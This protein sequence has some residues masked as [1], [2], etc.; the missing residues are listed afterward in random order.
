VIPASRSR[1]WRLWAPV[2][3]AIVVVAAVAACG[4]PAP[5]PS[6]PE[7]T[8]TVTPGP[9]AT[10]MPTPT[11]APVPTATPLASMVAVPT[12]RLAAPSAP[13]AH[14]DAAKTKALQTALIG[15][16][17]SNKLPG[18]SAAVLFPD[19]SIWTGVSGSAVV[20]KTSVTTDTLFSVGSIT[21]TFVAAL[22]GR[23]AMAGTIGLDDPLSKY[24]PDF[25]NAANI[26]LR[27]LLNHT[28][29]IDD[30]FDYQGTI[31]P[32]LLY[33]PTVT[34]TPAQVF[35][36]L[37]GPR[38]PKPGSNYYYS[39]TNYILLGL[40]IE[41]ATGQTVAALVRSEFLT[42]LGLT[43]TYL[44]T[45]ETAQGPKAHGYCTGTTAT[46][47]VDPPTAASPARGNSAG[48]MLPFT[49]E[50]TA[51]GFAGAYV[52]TASDL[53]IWANALYGGA[54][55]DQA[56]LAS[57]VDISQTAGLKTKPKYPYGMGFEQASVAGQLAWGHR[58]NLDGF[59]S[60]MEYL[61]AQHVTIVVMANCQWVV[62]PIPMA[63]I[64]AKI[65]IS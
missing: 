6:S 28:S 50:A 40:V 54:I 58:G 64:L 21:K 44:Q 4:S 65:A 63:S 60:T 33:R 24:V 14:L 12:S 46:C 23:L 42:P 2:A 53:A 9:T 8:S 37:L 41:K 25:P 36:R 13:V 48:T 57:M 22:V 7:A 19:G 11:P 51:V 17:S 34:W 15:I 35:A 1:P 56:T 18:V 38:F 29:G 47:G 20:G 39:N 3:A 32:A 62:D 31:G 10:P 27:E 49:S 5:T 55:L 59:W 16:R 30:L 45:E 43:H 52:S 26:T 61:P